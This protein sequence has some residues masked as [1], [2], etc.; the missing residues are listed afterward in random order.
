MADPNLSNMVVGI[1]C[2][3]DTVYYGYGWTKITHFG[4]CGE[5]YSLCRGFFTRAA[6]LCRNP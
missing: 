4:V 1:R 6:L 3:H 2:M 5:F